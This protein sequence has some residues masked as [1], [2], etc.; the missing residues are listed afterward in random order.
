MQKIIR[1]PVVLALAVGSIAAQLQQGYRSFAWT[2]DGADYWAPTELNTQTYN[3]FASSAGVLPQALDKRAENCDPSPRALPCT[4]I[5][6][7]SAGPITE[8]KLSGILDSYGKIDDVWTPAA[9]LQCVYLQIAL[10]E[11]F[12]GKAQDSAVTLDKD[13][14]TKFCAAHSVQYLFT[15]QILYST[16]PQLPAVFS[17]SPP[18]SIEIAA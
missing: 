1:L 4:V 8:E 2:V 6:I 16:V 3:Q 14:L 5:T 9:F 7:T 18:S 17:V 15:P 13:S 11:V 12:L 10:P